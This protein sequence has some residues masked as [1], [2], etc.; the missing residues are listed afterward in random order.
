MKEVRQCE[1]QHE[2]LRNQSTLESIKRYLIFAERFNIRN[3]FM[4]ENLLQFYKRIHR[5]STNDQLVHYKGEEFYDIIRARCSEGKTTF[6][7]RDFYKV[8]LVKS[9]GKLYYADRWILIDRPAIMFSSPLVPYAW[10]GIRSNGDDGRFLIFNEMFVRG[11]H[12]RASLSET[13]LFD[14]KMERVYFIDDA[15]V[16]SIDSL[17][18]KMEEVIHSDYSGKAD[19]L[20]CYLHLLIHEAMR[21]K[22]IS[23]YEP[24]NNAAKRI[25]ELFLALLDRQFPVDIPDKKLVLSTAN[26]YADRL[27]VHVNHLNRV[28][29]GATGKT[30]TQLINERIAQ[31][32]SQLLQHSSLS[33]GEIAFGMGFEE[34]S[35]FSKFMKKQTGKTPT[36]L[37]SKLVQ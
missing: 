27:N 8:S 16:A 32:S 14:P 18:D 2:T 11:D 31:E 36:E 10:E 9:Q 23:S 1:R 35:S 19:E 4:I 34:N 26:D 37:R 13:P 28:V 21:V 6:S 12:N 15:E 30:T 33:I 22:A 20:R 24:H 17:F 5:E 3:T 29:K 25:A 7:Y